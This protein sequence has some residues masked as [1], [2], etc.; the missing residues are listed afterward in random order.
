MQRDPSAW[1]R[2][3]SQGNTR[4]AT[5]AYDRGCIVRYG[6]MET[7]VL[8]VG[9]TILKKVRKTE[10]EW[11]AQLTPDAYRVTREKGTERA[12]S[13]R[14]WDSKEKGTY[15]CIGCGEPLF[16][17][18][19]KFDSATGW[20]SYWAPISMNAVETATDRNLAM[21][22][23]EVHCARCD[24]HLGHLFPDGP[25]PTGMRYCINSASLRF[26]KK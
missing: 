10:A 14:Y 4:G 19:T 13:G 5:R 9:G 2:Q 25:L 3:V 24:S 18:D 12:F 15:H 6:M 26:K 23:T 20:P 22:R 21:V 16:D 8:G 17:A 7:P 1:G 11:R